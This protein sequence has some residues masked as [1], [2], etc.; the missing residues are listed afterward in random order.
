MSASRGF[1]WTQVVPPDGTAAGIV[2]AGVD[3][4]ELDEFQ[5][6]VNVAGDGFLERTFTP[7]ELAFCAGRV[8]RLE[9]GRDL[10]PDPDGVAPREPARAVEAVGEGAAGNEL[11]REP[12]PAVGLARA[13][14]AGDPGV[15]D[16]GRG[17][18]L[19]AKALG[20][21]GLR[22]ARRCKSPHRKTC[23]N[24]PSTSRE[25]L[26]RRRRRRRQPIDRL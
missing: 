1:S 25:R 23:P 17:G 16:G 11:E 24:R 12:E 20:E 22:R 6:T 10:G 2:R 14:A 8:N 7:E 18:R 15:V 3:R 26:T 19:P 5:R 21:A 4:V 9:G 13:E